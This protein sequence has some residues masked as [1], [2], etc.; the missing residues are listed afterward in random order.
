MPGREA[1]GALTFEMIS[2]ILEEAGTIETFTDR[3]GALRVEHR[4]R[5][6]RIVG[7]D[8]DASGTILSG[9]PNVP[10]PELYQSL[11]VDPDRHP[12]PKL[13]SSKELPKK[14]VRVGDLSNIVRTEVVPIMMASTVG[15]VGDEFARG[16]S[17]F[18][19]LCRSPD[20][21]EV[22]RIQIKLVQPGS[23]LV[24][25]RGPFDERKFWK[26]VALLRSPGT[27][28]ND[29]VLLVQDGATNEEMM[30]LR[31]RLVSE[32][33]PA[34]R[35]KVLSREILDLFGIQ[36][37]GERGA[38]RRTLCRV[39]IGRR[40]RALLADMLLAQMT[41]EDVMD[42]PP[43]GVSPIYDTFHDEGI[44]HMAERLRECRKRWGC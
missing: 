18:D 4:D 15:I 43:R 27:L 24:D 31:D 10:P 9:C 23:P 20:T 22:E 14:A 40:N 32:R 37:V 7:P 38:F 3:G 42:I 44:M 6:G 8:E 34:H 30:A 2:R 5:S 13:D 11:L 28:V 21:G 16:Q 29:A 36:F 35:V 1:S 41:A 25:P 26:L 19:I 33:V 17:G 12:A 39:D